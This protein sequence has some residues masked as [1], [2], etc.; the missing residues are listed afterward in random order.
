MNGA[1][2]DLHTL[3]RRVR[4]LTSH[5]RHNA[6]EV[7]PRFGRLDFEEDGTVTDAGDDLLRERGTGPC[8][9]WLYSLTGIQSGCIAA[10]LLGSGSSG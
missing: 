3:L 4:Q 7:L 10:T 9:S 5:Q 6:A 8:A 1:R 2:E